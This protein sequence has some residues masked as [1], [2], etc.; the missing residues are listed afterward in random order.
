[1]EDAWY[2]D[3]LASSNLGHVVH[4]ANFWNWSEAGMSGSSGGEGQ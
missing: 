1:M 3:Q 2:P 4:Y